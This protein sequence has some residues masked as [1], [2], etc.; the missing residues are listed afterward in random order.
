MSYNPK[1]LR[2]RG[3]QSQVSPRRTISVKV[4]AGIFLKKR[5]PVGPN[6][7][8]KSAKDY[9]SR[10][11]AGKERNKSPLGLY[12]KGKAMWDYQR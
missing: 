12:S 6:L 5:M 8:T 2:V 4:S 1:D 7:N 11:F 9:L 3:S 10:K